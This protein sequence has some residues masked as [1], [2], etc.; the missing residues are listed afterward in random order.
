LAKMDHVSTITTTMQ[1]RYQHADIP[2]PQ[3]VQDLVS[4]L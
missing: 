4:Y 2:M 1:C 3:G